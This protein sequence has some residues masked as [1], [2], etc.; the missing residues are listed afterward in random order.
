MRREGGS[1]RCGKIEKLSPFSPTPKKGKKKGI[2]G[3]GE[4][5]VIVVST[6]ENYVP[7]I[8]S[9]FPEENE[10]CS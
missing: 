1:F 5:G 3:E 8:F 7:E 10:N 9:S 2:M 4:K 6:K